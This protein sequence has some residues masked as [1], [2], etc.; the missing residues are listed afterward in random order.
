LDEAINDYLE[1]VAP[2][3]MRFQS[4]VVFGGNTSR[5]R[6]ADKGP[7]PTLEHT[8]LLSMEIDFLSILQP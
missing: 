4:A 7:T 6:S 8:D 1:S 3:G 5:R 2:D